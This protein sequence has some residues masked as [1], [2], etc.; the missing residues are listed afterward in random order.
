V[1]SARVRSI[2]GTLAVIAIGAAPAVGA[3]AGKPDPSARPDT[4]RDRIVTRS[5]PAHAR[6]EDERRYSR[7][8]PLPDAS[9][10]A[11]ASAYRDGRARAT[12]ERARHAR[13]LQDSTL[14]S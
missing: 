14:T 5:E 6:H 12:I 10:S 9:P 8:G 11:V 4:T 13:F 2:V 1:P 3:Q 7:R